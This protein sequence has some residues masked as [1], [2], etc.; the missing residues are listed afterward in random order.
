[1]NALASV[2]A[3]VGARQDADDE[4]LL[5][6]HKRFGPLVD[7]VVAAALLGALWPVL[8]GAA[9]AVRLS[10]RGPILFRQVRIGRG[11]V[12]FEVLKFRTMRP[13]ADDSRHR[14]ALAEELREQGPQSSATSDGVFKLENDDRITSVGAFLRRYSIDEL[15]QLLNVCRGEMAIVG[16][17]PLPPYEVEMYSRRHRR[18]DAVAP[19]LTGLWQVS[20]RNLLSSTQMLELDLRYLADRSWS[21]DLRIL[22]RTPGVLLR[23][24]GAR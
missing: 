7:R 10:G 16:P 12:P 9:L 2:S 14:D 15:P 21:T 1:M 6:G 3:P 5:V 13:G 4:P 23:G 8:L 19:G 24:D 22:A 20:G 11:G 17:R 18:R